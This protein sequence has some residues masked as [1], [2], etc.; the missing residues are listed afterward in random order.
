ME[1]YTGDRERKQDHSSMVAMEKSTSCVHSLDNER[2]N[3][4]NRKCVKGGGG[5]IVFFLWLFYFITKIGQSNK[6]H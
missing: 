3:G 5:A 1:N 4:W 6:R 2:A